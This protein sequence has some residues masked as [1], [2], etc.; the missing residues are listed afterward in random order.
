MRQ[1]DQLNVVYSLLNKIPDENKSDKDATPPKESNDYSN[2]D[3]DRLQKQQDVFLKEK[4]SKH[5]LIITYIWLSFLIGIFIAA[6]ISNLAF[7]KPYASD[8]VLIALVSSTSF[9]AIMGMIS[10]ILRNLF[11]AKKQ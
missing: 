6:G 4:F 8:A 7:N 2:R 3:I 9:S 5:V 10:I 1:Q 11:Q